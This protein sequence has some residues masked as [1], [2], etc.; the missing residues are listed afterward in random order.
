MII[1]KCTKTTWT[2]LAISLFVI[3]E[4]GFKNI[5]SSAIRKGFVYT[6]HKKKKCYV[7]LRP[8]SSMVLD[9]FSIS[10]YLGVGT[11]IVKYPSDSYCYSFISNVDKKVA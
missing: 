11:S 5:Q 1:D 7:G 10:L 9:S 6:R 3:S 2:T 8:D 4:I